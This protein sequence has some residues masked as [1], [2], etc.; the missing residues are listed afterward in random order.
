MI[1]AW[2]AFNQGLITSRSPKDLPIFCEMVVE[3]FDKGIYAVQPFTS[4][5]THE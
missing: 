1:P 3:E 5:S 4:T 2:S